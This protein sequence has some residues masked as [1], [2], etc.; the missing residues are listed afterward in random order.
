MD[1]E[2]SLSQEKRNKSLSWLMY[3]EAC[4]WAETFTLALAVLILIFLFAFKYVTVDGDSMTHTLQN[5]D[6]L[7]IV[8]TY[9]SYKTGDIVVVQVP[10]HEE[11]LIKRVIATEGQT[12]EIDFENWIV[13]V[14]GVQLDE[15]YVRK[16]KD[17]IM[18]YWMFY[19][20]KFTVAEGKMFVMG[21]NRNNSNDSRNPEIGQLDVRQALGK[22]VIRFLP[23]DKFGTVN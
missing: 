1:K 19:N 15:P 18:H 10:G 13:T 16:D 21:D 6:R 17:E 12:V 22:V 23:F 11:P 5:E 7:I 9:G 20:G 2:N 14:D 3:E 4:D 8:N